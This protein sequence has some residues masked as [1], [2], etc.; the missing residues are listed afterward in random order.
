VLWEALA[1]R[2]RW[3]LVFDGADDPR[4][5]LP[6]WPP[7]GTGHVLVTSRN[8]TWGALAATISVEVLPRAQAV[9]FLAQRTGSQD[10]AS[11]ERLAAAL[12]DLPLALEQA[13]AYLEETAAGPGDYL[14]LL[15]AH[16]S[17]LLALGRPGNT[18]Q[19]IA[20]TWTVALER[21]R[22]LAPVAEDLLRLCA[23][24][25]PDA[26]PRALLTDHPDVLPEQ[27]AAAVRDGLGVQQALGVLR[28][29]SLVRITGQE[30][31][32]HRLVQA[33]VRQSLTSDDR[34]R[35]AATAVALIGAGFPGQA[36]EVTAWPAAA[37]LLP[38]AVAAADLAV[39]VG[40]D[41]P[42]TAMLLEEAGRYLLGRADHAR[43]RGMFERALAIREAR[44]GVDHPD[45][46]ASL[47]NLAVVLRAQGDFKG[48]R[49]LL[50]RAL[51][52]RE[53]RLG[54]DHPDTAAS[55]S[56]LAGV[57]RVQ[58]DLD[59]SRSLYERC[60]AIDEDRLGADHSATASSLNNLAVVLHDQGDLDG[61]RAHYERA[62]A[63]R[64][65]MLGPDHPDTASSLNNLAVVLS[66]LGDLDGAR[67]LH[68]RAL[69]IRQ[70]M[71]GPDHP[72]TATSLN[73]LAVVLSDL[74]DLDGAR[75]HYERALRIDEAAYG[76]D[77]PTVAI[78]IT[79]LANVLSEQ[80]DLDGAR[81][82][83]ERA[84][85]IDEA[86]YGPDHPS[87]ADDA[88][89][90]GGVLRE[91]GDLDGAR[92]HFERALRI[93]EATHGPDHPATRTVAAN[94][95]ALDAPG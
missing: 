78:R 68:E 51:S 24:L 93:Y 8:P 35:W 16:G 13:A 50:E 66:D 40:A 48:A 27:L 18:E 39:A 88:N 56:N 21:V 79:N 81:V 86:G 38:H 47:N 32:V 2:D 17:E 62:L 76:P 73:N 30:L 1:R 58:G 94:L 3:L 5:L 11:L 34:Q 37:L 75:A 20:T 28:R 70:A 91:L 29:Y 42:A 59:G 19:T 71:L 92:A 67:A 61:A 49:Y 25:A 89:N 44:L 65:A 52:V 9:G 63:I 6:Y 90:L 43:A 7:G 85:R 4:G 77:H 95:R 82:L 12:G 31:G 22:E 84:L 53:A 36:E 23:H 80:G 72:D 46:A 83:C 69:A 54:G 41:T 10:R 14:A 87:V 64:Q 55:L 15:G 60:L 33:V 45:T 57:L 74:G 26:I